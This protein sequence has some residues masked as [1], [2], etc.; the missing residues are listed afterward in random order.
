[1]VDLFCLWKLCLFI[2]PVELTL[3]V[4]NI[5]VTDGNREVAVQVGFNIPEAAV[6]GI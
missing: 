4:T 3:R 1:M 6:M 5:S 2:A